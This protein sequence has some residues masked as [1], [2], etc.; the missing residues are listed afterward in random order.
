[1]QKLGIVGA[2]CHV[3]EVPVPTVRQWFEDE[4]FALGIS[5]GFFGFYAHCGFVSALEEDR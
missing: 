4:P 5:S 3:A 2:R 1:M